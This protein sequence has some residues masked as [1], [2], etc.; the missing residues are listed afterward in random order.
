MI[1]KWGAIAGAWVLIVTAG[2][3]FAD[4]LAKFEKLLKPEIPPDALT[5]KSA[6]AIGDS[7]FSLQ[8]VVIT[9]PPSGDEK[10]EPIKIKS[11]T[12]EDAD[13]DAI[14]K[15]APPTFLKLRI[16]GINI[17]TKAPNGMDLKEMADIDKLAANFQLDYRL[18]PAKKSFNLNRL[19]LDVS[20]LARLELTMILDGVSLDDLM[21]PDK[22]MEQATLRTASLVYDDRSLLGKVIPAIA[23]MQ[24]SKTEEFVETGTKMLEEMEK[25]VGKAAKKVL[26]TL[27]AYLGD[28]EQP[29]GALRITVNPPDKASLAM[30]SSAKS[31]D[32]VIKALGLEVTYSGH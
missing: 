1:R 6:K 25:G 26:E 31:P 18:D 9:P 24:G 15:K 32:E 14:E 20:E 29:K 7:G 5:Y 3:A 16:E 23:K 30:V 13:F 21:Q 28:Y 27:S 4:G 22:A 11:I 8:D 19:E 10:P 2:P 12:V 17:P